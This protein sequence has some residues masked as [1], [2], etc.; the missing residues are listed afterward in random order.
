MPWKPRSPAPGQNPDGT[1]AYDPSRR[2]RSSSRSNP[3]QEPSPAMAWVLPQRLAVGR[4]PRSGDLP[5][6]QGQGIQVLLTLCS[7]LEAQLN[8]SLAAQFQQ[9]SCP[10]PDHRDATPLEVP[11]LAAAVATLHQCLQ[12]NQVVYVHCLAGL[13]RS[14][15][16]CL[17]YLCRYHGLEVHEGLRYLKENYPP[18]SPT[19]DQLQVIRAYLQTQSP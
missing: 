9:V 14:P 6:L 17:A 1:S 15:T 16:V 13:E 7:T 10:M 11:V 3:P 4:F 12:R 8:P 2:S 18:A 5:I 19:I